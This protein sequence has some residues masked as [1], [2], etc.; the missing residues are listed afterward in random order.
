MGNIVFA[1]NPPKIT[2]V[3]DA[4]NYTRL[5]SVSCSIINAMM[6]WSANWLTYKDTFTPVATTSSMP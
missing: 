1:D 2:G 5:V 3:S 6:V 4:N